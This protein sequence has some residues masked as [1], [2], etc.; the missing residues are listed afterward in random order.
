M[1]TFKNS[2]LKTFEQV[3]QLSQPALIKVLSRFLKKH[4][5]KVIEN[6]DY[7][8]AEGDI[9]IA[10]V[11]H[12]DTVFVS[13]PEEIFFDSRLNMMTSPQG[14][15]ADDRAG[16]FAI[17]QIIRSGLKPH[18]VFTTDEEMGGIGAAKLA[19]LG[20]PFSDLRYVI[21]LDRRGADDCVFYD[22][23]NPIFT[24][25]IESFGFNWN[26]GSFS[27][28]SILCPIWGVAGVNLSVGYRDEHTKS[29]VLYV[30]Q[31]YNT[32]EKVKTMLTQEDIPHFEYIGA[33]RN[34]WGW[35]DIS[36]N[37]ACGYDEIGRCTHCNKL[38][39]E[40]ELFPTVMQN[41]TTGFY[42]PECLS[43]VAWCEHCDSAYE[44]YSPE[45]PDLGTCP[46]CLEERNDKSRANN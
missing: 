41:G 39:M 21:E 33:K 20:R 37:T 35:W 15:G 1:R 10:L 32:I 9:P 17:L 18:I 2:D 27:D 42:C 38:Y 13:P 22:C 24:D 8:V 36:Y 6:E 45:A 28:I 30:G 7:I 26:W 3:L 16:V 43:E 46:K 40:E 4:Y 44:K 11:A 34:K 5:P 19:G 14:L 25:Y 29:E 31:L 12:M 23:D